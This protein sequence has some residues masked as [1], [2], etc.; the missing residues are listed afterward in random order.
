MAEP[1]IYLSDG[2]ALQRR[3]EKWSLD[4][5]RAGKRFR[6]SLGTKDRV[7]AIDMGNRILADITD[8]KS[9]IDF[10]AN[11]IEALVR[12]HDDPGTSGLLRRDALDSIVKFADHLRLLAHE[13]NEGTDLKEMIQDSVVACVGQPALPAPVKNETAIEGYGVYQLTIRRN[14]KDIKG[15][16]GRWTKQAGNILREFCKEQKVEY[17]GDITRKHIKAHIAPLKAVSTVRNHLTAISGYLNWGMVEEKYIK[18]NVAEGIEIG[19][20]DEKHEVYYHTS[21]ELWRLL[22]AA[23]G[24]GIYELLIHWALYSNLRSDE[25][26]AQ[27]AED[28]NPD[29]RV[30]S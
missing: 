5:Y 15:N 20:D 26:D 9:M 21:E 24:E 27:Q 22:E 1:R 3:G 19:V 14:R 13:A 12:F 30:V 28:I 16:P 6:R 4:V 7:R 11:N 17:I 23:K 18:E 2:V 10:H 25:L 8:R 29:A